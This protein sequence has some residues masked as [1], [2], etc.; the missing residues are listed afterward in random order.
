VATAEPI[1]PTVT[2]STVDMIG[3]ADMEMVS[4]LVLAFA[5]S[6]P[7]ESAIEI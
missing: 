6:L 5:M 4:R 1:A 3:L 2:V 7:A